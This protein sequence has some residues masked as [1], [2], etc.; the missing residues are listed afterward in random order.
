MG[1]QYLRVSSSNP[2]RRTSSD[3]FRT[4]ATTS[5]TVSGNA[6][7]GPPRLVSPVFIFPVRLSENAEQ[8]RKD[9]LL[10]IAR[11]VQPASRF[12][13]R[14]LGVAANERFTVGSISEPGGRPPS[15]RERD[16]RPAPPR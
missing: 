6:C 5:Q 4:R 13:V 9:P 10:T 12:F 8:T 16:R 11:G 14:P 15:S 3:G 7:W 1:F 2:A